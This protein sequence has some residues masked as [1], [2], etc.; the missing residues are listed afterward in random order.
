MAEQIGREVPYKV[1]D[2][3]TVPTRDS[4][5]RGRGW[6]QGIA[7]YDKSNRLGFYEGVYLLIGVTPIGVI[8]GFSF[9]LSNINDFVLAET[10]LA[11]RANPQPRLPNVGK[12]TVGDYVAD[13]G[14]SKVT[15]WLKHY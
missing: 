3:S 6:L 15:H 14:F 1:L 2:A 12:L 8:I 5:R 13:K 7:N 4:K 11:A 9:G 10:F